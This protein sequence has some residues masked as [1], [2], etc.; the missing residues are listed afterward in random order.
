MRI[1]CNGILATLVVEMIDET[2]QV[3]LFTE[4]QAIEGFV[5]TQFIALPSN[6][7]RIIAIS[8]NLE[9]VRARLFSLND[10]Q[11]SKRRRPSI[12]VSPKKRRLSM[13]TSPKKRR[14]SMELAISMTDLF[15]VSKTNEVRVAEKRD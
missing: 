13:D 5:L 12:N 15:A 4:K 1:P 9:L 10:G 7:F 11:G 3:L 8:A 2:E 14:L 6:P